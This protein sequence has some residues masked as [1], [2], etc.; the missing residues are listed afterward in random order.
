MFYN[1]LMVSVAKLRVINPIA[2]IIKATYIIESGPFLSTIRPVIG[3]DINT[4]TKGV[5]YS[6]T[7]ILNLF[8]CYSLLS[9][10]DFHSSIIFCV[11]GSHRLSKFSIL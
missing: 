1:L 11:I 3:L 7:Q 10:L 2:K 8:S 6:P 5:G 9:F 4:T